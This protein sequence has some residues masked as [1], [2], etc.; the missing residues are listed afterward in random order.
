MYRV[1]VL[2]TKSSLFSL[3]QNVAFYKDKSGRGAFICKSKGKNRGGKVKCRVVSNAQK[4]TP[5]SLDCG[6]NFDL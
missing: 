4:G 6:I 3:F 2:Y 5:Q 1:T